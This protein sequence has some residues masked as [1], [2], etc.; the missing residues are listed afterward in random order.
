MDILNKLAKFAERRVEEYGARYT[1]F[2]VFYALSLVLPIYMWTVTT[3][4]YTSVVTFR[5]LATVFGFLL[6]I[7]TTW[8]PFFKK[9]LPLFWYF[10]IMFCLPFFNT[11]LI[12]IDGLSLFWIVNLTIALILGMVLLDFSS[13]IIIFPS[14]AILALLCAYLLGHQITPAHVPHNIIYPSCYLIFFVFVIAIVFFKDKEKTHSDK[15]KAMKSLAGL[16]AHEIRTPL[17]TIIVQLTLLNS[18]NEKNDKES[19]KN[20][21]QIMLNELNTIN[22]TI[23]MILDRLQDHALNVDCKA[24]PISSYINSAINRY[25]FSDEEGDLI[26]INVINDFELS[27]NEHLMSQVLFNLIQNALYQIKAA[28]KGEIYITAYS[29]RKRDI[30]SIKDTATGIKKEIKERLFEPFST[31]K[32]CGTGIGL[33]FCKTTLRIMNGNIR[34]ESVYG[35]YTNFIIEF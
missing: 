30:L 23:N 17:S 6:A 35:E 28:K 5:V 1:A 22:Y 21:T 13:F 31:S 14:G 7:S 8:Y 25:P 4:K 33:Y 2:G 34:C 16:I 15:I 20:R 3:A 27:A 18:L 12:I 19:L 24:M 11:Y 10:A 29:N 26:H 9:Y 32:S